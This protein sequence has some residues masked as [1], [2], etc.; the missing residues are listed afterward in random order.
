M[1][2]DL[3]NLDQTSLD[4]TRDSSRLDKAKQSPAEHTQCM[5]SRRKFLMTSGVA[6]GG[7][8]LVSLTLYPGTA[9][10]QQVQAKVTSYPRQ[11]VGKLSQLKVNQPLYFN[12]PD[13]GPNSRA[14]LV[15][16]GVEGGGGIGQ[17]KDVV[18]FSMMCTHQGGPLDNQYKVR[19]E[20]RVVG[21]CP[22]HLSTFDLRRHGII[23]SGQAY[24]SLPQVLLEQ[25]GD[26]LYA[27]GIMG[28]LFGRSYNLIAV[29]GA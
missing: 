13:E 5:M 9:Q 7:A 20:H 22:F 24:E 17:N 18:A 4:Q 2:D 6:V 8:S 19:D 11:L 3:T 28:L 27:V 12:Y 10:A 16:M 23:V 25:E 26:L 15:R 14:M 29:A 21:Q 1:K